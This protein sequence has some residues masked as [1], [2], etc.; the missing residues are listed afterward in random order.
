MESSKWTIDASH[1]GV[2]FAVRHM[3]FAKVRGRFTAFQGT[4]ELDEADFTRSKVE[5]EIDAASI[6]TGVGDRDK[7]LRSADFLDAEQFPKL[8]FVSKTI[9]K[10]GSDHYR[11]HGTLTVRDV[12]RDVVLD[13]EYGGQA[14]D[15]WG[16][17]R[18]AF[19]AKTGLD[20]GD[21]GLKWNQAL[22]AGGVLVGERVEI[23]LEVQLVKAAASKAA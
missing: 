9:E 3:V 20:R 7:H 8:R 2:N 23:E 15:P 16:N 1:S 18:A 6:D 10:A 12:T 22:E 13:A 5:V 21:F 14:K 17:Q 11:V 4:V 19:T